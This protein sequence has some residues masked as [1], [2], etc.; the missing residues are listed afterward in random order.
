MYSET[1]PRQGQTTMIFIVLI[2]IIFLG[3]GVFLLSLAQ[4]VSQSEYINLYTHNLLSSLVKTDTGYT[5][6]SCK[7]VADLLSCSFLSPTHICGTQDCF[8]LSEQTVNSY[9]EQF[10]FIKEGFRYLLIVESVGFTALPQ[11][12]PHKVEIGDPSLKEEKIEKI[13][14][15]ERIQKVVGGNPY[16][17]NIRLIIAK[18]E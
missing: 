16:L 6:A 15:N 4:T 12:V 2:I 3:M 14:A 13:T 18:K 1:I 5:D 11:G 7:T 10:A 9:M 17:L 8:S